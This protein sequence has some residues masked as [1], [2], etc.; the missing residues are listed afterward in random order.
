[1][2]KFV[3]M[4]IE[5]PQETRGKEEWAHPKLCSA[6]PASPGIA[7]LPSI[8]VTMKWSLFTSLSQRC[9]IISLAQRQWG[10]FFFHLDTTTFLM[11][12]QGGVHERVLYLK[13]RECKVEDG[14][15][16]KHRSL[17][18]TV[19][20]SLSHR[21]LIPKDGICAK[22][23]YP[24]G[25]QFRRMVSVP[26]ETI[27]SASSSED[28]FW[29]QSKHSFLEVH[30][31]RAWRRS[32]IDIVSISCSWMSVLSDTDAILMVHSHFFINGRNS[33]PCTTL[34]PYHSQFFWF[35][36]LIQ[37]PTPSLESQIPTK[38]S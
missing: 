33:R 22:W 16:T 28:N 8:H 6:L 1:M 13:W 12:D 37:E 27:P 11:H 25:I 10:I 26:N 15:N 38:V 30:Y 7:I 19:Q 17:Q 20:R 31:I 5:S 3:L 35:G 32:D 36:C 18:P 24:I 34:M 4:K 2:Q 9:Y 29:A 23:N 14:T 21:H